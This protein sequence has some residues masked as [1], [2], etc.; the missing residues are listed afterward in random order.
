M[1]T[2]FDRLIPGLAQQWNNGTGID[3]NSWIS[4]I[5][6]YDHLLDYISILWPKFVLYDGCALQGLPD[7]KNDEDFM[8]ALGGDKTAVERASSPGVCR[9]AGAA[10]GSTAR[11]HGIAGILGKR[12]SSL[13]PQAMKR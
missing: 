11:L 6:R 12:S 13:I 2:E 10:Q 8:R 7:P 4:C 5:G 9:R 1:V 3:A